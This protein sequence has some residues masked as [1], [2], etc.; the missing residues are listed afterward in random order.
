MYIN[1]NQQIK[2]EIIIVTNVV[3]DADKLQ[4]MEYCVFDKWSTF[5]TFF[6]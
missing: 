5:G 2:E 1:A 4:N 3:R 6:T